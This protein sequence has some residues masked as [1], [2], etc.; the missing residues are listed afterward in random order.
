MATI[1][2]DS[3]SSAQKKLG[4]ENPKRENTKNAT[5]SCVSPPTSADWD[6]TF[7]GAAATAMDDTVVPHRW[8]AHQQL[9]RRPPGQCSRPTSDISWNP[10]LLIRILTMACYNPYIYIR[11]YIWVGCHPL[12]TYIKQPGVFYHWSPGGWLLNSRFNVSTT[13]SIFRSRASHPQTQMFT[14]Q[15]VSR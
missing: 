2:R 12:Y 9:S 6:S 8:G 4:P 13:C 7:R 3:L 14:V 1:L 5:S 11:I 10:G 15:L